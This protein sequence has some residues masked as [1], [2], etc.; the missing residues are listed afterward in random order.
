VLYLVVHNLEGPGLRAGARD[1][2][3]ATLCALAAAPGVRL[4]GSMD[5]VGAGRLW[6]PEVRARLKA[7]FH[8]ATTFARYDAEIPHAVAGRG[9]PHAVAGR[10]AGA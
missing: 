6:T 5:H 4:V 2:G 1:G 9:I 10:G 7:A 3:L 8:D